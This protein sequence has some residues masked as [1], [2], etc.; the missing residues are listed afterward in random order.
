MEIRKTLACACVAAGAF[1]A[2]HAP[3]AAPVASA[4]RAAGPAPAK[5][6]GDDALVREAR[7]LA[8]HV[9]EVFRDRYAPA[10]LKARTIGWSLPGELRALR[11]VID[12]KPPPSKAKLQRA[13]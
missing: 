6:E 10:E 7:I 13:F 12:E 9:E 3:S 11:G 5:T 4:P 1:V 2:C 8:D